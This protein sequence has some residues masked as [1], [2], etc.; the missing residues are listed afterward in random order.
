MQSY[1]SIPSELSQLCSFPSL[2]SFQNQISQSRVST[3]ERLFCFGPKLTQPNAHHFSFPIQ[4]T[5]RL[6]LA[7]HCAVPL[8]A[9]FVVQPV[10]ALLITT[11]DLMSSN[12]SANIVFLLASNHTHHVRWNSAGVPVLPA[13]GSYTPHSIILRTPSTKTTWIHLSQLYINFL[14]H[15]TGFSC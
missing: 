2:V 14:A 15:T 6:W 12:F 4:I 13:L 10:S 11:L 3:A 9:H 8:I 1:Y 5:S 7:I